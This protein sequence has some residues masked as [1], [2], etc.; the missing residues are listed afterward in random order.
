MLLRILP[1]LASLP[2]AWLTKRH[3]TSLRRAMPQVAL[4]VCTLLARSLVNTRS[5]SR[6]VLL[7]LPPVKEVRLTERLATSPDDRRH[8]GYT[9][10]FPSKL[11]S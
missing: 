10:L 7:A 9:S 2:P 5:L 4:A 6:T 1:D 3:I 11:S 8:C